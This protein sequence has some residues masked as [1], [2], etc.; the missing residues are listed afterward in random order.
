MIVHAH[1]IHSIQSLVPFLI[2]VNIPFTN[3]NI[4]DLV[5]LSTIN[6]MIGAASRYLY[7]NVVIC[8]KAKKD[9]EI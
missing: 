8:M 1:I 2:I 3:V 5:V 7:K 6:K 4:S 9:L